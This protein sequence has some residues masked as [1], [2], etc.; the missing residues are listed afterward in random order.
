MIRRGIIV[1]LMAMAMLVPMGA[2]LSE[3]L[4]L[5]PCNDP[6]AVVVRV[7]QTAKVCANP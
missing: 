7:G 1:A 2:A 6:D 5:G 3:P 4:E